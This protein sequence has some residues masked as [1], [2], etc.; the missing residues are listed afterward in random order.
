M[1]TYLRIKRR[2]WLDR[3]IESAQYW[4]ATHKTDGAKQLKML[5]KLQAKRKEL[6]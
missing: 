3:K 4:L 5:A 2:A 6:I 1:K